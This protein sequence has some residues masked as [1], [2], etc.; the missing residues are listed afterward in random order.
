MS[1]KTFGALNWEEPLH[2]GGLGC[3]LI[4]AQPDVA[5]RVKR[6]LP[7]VQESRLGVIRVADSIEVAR[8]IQWLISRW[9][10]EMSPSVL[11]R[12]TQGARE[13]RQQGERVT[14]ILSGVA[15]HAELPLA[16]DSDMTPRQYQRVA[17]DLLKATGGLLLADDLG[18]G[19]TLSCTLALA[20]PDQRPALVVTLT[21]LPRQW[22]RELNKT[23]P[24]LAGHEVTKATPYDLTDAEGRTPDLIAMNYAKLAGWADHLAGRVKTV[25]FDEV[26][27]LR[28]DTSKRHAGALRVAA[29]ADLVVGA[30]AT[31]V[32]NFGGE[33]YSILSV[34]RPD[35]VWDRQEFARE[36]CKSTYGLD[37]KTRI[38]DPAA[39]R[40][41]L[42]DQGAMLR[43]TRPEVGFELPPVTMIEQ[44]VDVDEKI[45]ADAAS[46]A[47]EIARLILDEGATHRERWVARSELD[48]RMRQATG[49][50]KARFVADFTR[51]VLES[52]EKVILAGWHRDVWAIWMERLEDLRPVLYTGTE[53]PAQKARAFDSF[54]DGDSRILMLS[55]RSGAGLDGLQDIC[56][57]IVF[58][59][60]DW[61]PGVHKQ[62][63]GRLHRPG[64]LRPVSAYFCTTDF[65][66]DPYM[67]EVLNIKQMEADM[68]IDPEASVGAEV[69]DPSDHLARLAQAV[70]DG[71][72]AHPKVSLGV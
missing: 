13:H 57:A 14:D 54:R 12:L 44:Y 42:T 70:L 69:V 46:S 24:D 7:R 34:L 19:K 39:F 63:V 56:N 27:E 8:D 17:Y 37:S 72:T 28:R 30:S 29:A 71:S 61:S 3:W 49:V 9:P 35:L 10:L 32:Y 66:A 47:T 52:E 4:E 6:I 2:D 15:E 25:I 16:P 11:S 21:G 67:S 40:Q 62:V 23:F 65:G 50:A 53:S 5:M 31:P 38:E 36:W 41:W 33:M 26:Q 51:L 48:W 64:Q 43:R 60:L 59:E 18:L 55:L 45:T 58:G 20:D 22:L 1:S 68:L